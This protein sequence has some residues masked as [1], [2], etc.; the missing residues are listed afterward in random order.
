MFGKS[1]NHNH[2]HNENHMKKGAVGICVCPQCGYSVL[3]QRGVPCFKLICPSCKISLIKQNN[4]GNKFSVNKNS[5]VNSFP[6]IDVELCA[7][8]GACVN[9]CLPGAIIMAD[10]KAKIINEKCINCRAC[11]DACPAEAII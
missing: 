2:K 6:V 7:G 1:N 10:N 4:A 3:H 5:K 9:E 8:C 11:I